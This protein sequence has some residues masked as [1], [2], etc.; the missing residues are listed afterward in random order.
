[1]ERKKNYKAFLIFLKK[2]TITGFNDI[3]LN[4]PLLVGLEKRMEDNDQFFYILDFTRL[5]VI[6]SSKRSKQMMGLAPEDV[7][8]RNIFIRTHPNEIKRHGVARSKMFQ[9]AN[10][11]NS[12]PEDDFVVA[13]TNYHFLDINENYRNLLI[14]GY[15]FK[16]KVPEPNVYGILI[17]TDISKF[18]EIKYG[19]NFYLGKDMDMFRYPDKEL[20]STGCVFSKREFEI[21]SLIKAGLSSEQI[22][23][24]IFLS[25]HTIDTHRRNIIK[26]TNKSSTAELIFELQER[27]FF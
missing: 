5:R 15:V 25:I 20:V 16:S 3:D 13:S 7:N 23:Q 6:F 21:L 11:M 2:Y 12:S 8:A 26:K 1:M 17:H 4:D 22:A 9:R 24:K 19:Y 10:E 18:G 14:Q 27:G